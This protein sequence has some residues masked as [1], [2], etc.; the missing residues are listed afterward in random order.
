MGRVSLI[1]MTPTVLDWIVDTIPSDLKLRTL[2]AIHLATCVYLKNANQRIS[3]A[4]YDLRMSAAATS[5]NIPLF[6]S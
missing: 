3:L 1:E 2:D 5:L 6:E 4:S